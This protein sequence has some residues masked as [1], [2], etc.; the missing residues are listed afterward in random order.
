M[1]EASNDEVNRIETA[2]DTIPMKQLPLEEVLMYANPSHFEHTPAHD[3]LIHFLE[4]HDSELT[5]YPALL[6]HI[7]SK[8]NEAFM[9]NDDTE[10]EL[11]GI[12]MR[13]YASDDE[14]MK[15]YNDLMRD[16]ER[17]TR[18]WSKNGWMLA[19]I[20]SPL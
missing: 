5:Q 2:H 4:K 19:E 10:V 16:V 7:L 6:Q 8:L 12:D 17:H 13:K 3:R 11:P 20:D 1:I 14:T 18:K 9:Q 15:I